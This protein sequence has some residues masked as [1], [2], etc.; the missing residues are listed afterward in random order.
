LLFGF[1]SPGPAV[2]EIVRADQGNNT[3]NGAITV[4]GFTAN[5]VVKEYVHEVHARPEKVFPLL[6]PVREYE[7]IEG[8][9]CDMLYSESGV[10]EDNCVFRTHLPDR[11]EATWVVSKYDRA[12]G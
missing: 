9:N 7:W 4:M 10:A 2:I 5:R 3:P 8:W 12:R 1:R 11:G 6:C